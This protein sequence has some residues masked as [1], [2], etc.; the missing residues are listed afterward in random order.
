[1]RKTTGVESNSLLTDSDILKWE[2]E[3]K[4]L[5][6]RLKE[7]DVKLH[8]IDMHLQAAYFLMGKSSVPFASS[9][10]RT[11]IECIK[12]ALV[13]KELSAPEIKR[14]LTAL[15]TNVPSIEGGY[16][17]KVLDRAVSRGDIMK[18]DGKYKLSPAAPPPE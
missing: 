4:E 5:E 12:V 8:T 3:R 7:L 10:N 1:M 16:F 18:S 2:S 14:S 9:A 15:R 6:V 13:G 17:F 11:L